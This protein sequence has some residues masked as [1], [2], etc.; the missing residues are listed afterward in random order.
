MANALR[1]LEEKKIYF[2]LKGEGIGG[3]GGR[4]PF[5]SSIGQDI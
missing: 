1:R 2:F 5:A 4:F 3:T